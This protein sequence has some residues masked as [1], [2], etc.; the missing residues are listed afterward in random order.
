MKGRGA[1][2]VLGFRRG[3]RA[4]NA[5]GWPIAGF[6]KQPVIRAHPSLSR[7]RL[8]FAP[9]ILTAPEH[10]VASRACCVDLCHVIEFAG[11]RIENA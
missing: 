1:R 4:S 6:L 2:L 5:D 11:F 9:P 10:G 3:V 8:R 7:I